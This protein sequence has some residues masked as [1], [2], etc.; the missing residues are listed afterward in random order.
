MKTK[1]NLFFLILITIFTVPT[2]TGLLHPGFFVTDDGNWM[3]IRFSAFYEALR[4]GQFPVRF[5]YRLNNSYGYPVADF[6]Y[7]L[8]MYIGVFIHI[9]KFNFVDTI[10]II[11]GLSMLGSSIFCFLWLKKKYTN[12]SAMIGTIAYTFFP[13]HLYD[14][15]VRGSIGEVLALAILPFIFWQIERNNLVFASLGIALLITAHNSLALLLLPVIFI[16]IVL[17]HS[18]SIKKW[19]YSFILGFGLSAF[20]WVPAIYDRQYTFFDKIAVSNYSNYFITEKDVGLIGLVSVLAVLVSIVLF[21][22]KKNILFVYF[23]VLSIIFTLLTQPFSKI[24]WDIFPFTNLIQFPFRLL[25]IV[26]LAVA[27]L[28]AYQINL[29]KGKKLFFVSLVYVLIIFISS[30][31]YIYPKNF[32]NYPDTFYSTNLDSTTVKNEY[33]PIWLKNIPIS[34]ASKKVK[35]IDGKGEI[36]NLVNNGNLSFTVKTDRKSQILINTIYYPGFIVRVNGSSTPID[37]KQLG[38]IKFQ[39]DKGENMVAVKF[40]E[41]PIRLFADFIS[42]IFLILLLVPPILKINNLHSNKD[43]L[44]TAF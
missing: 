28:I 8:F 26:C 17:L 38:L 16:Y 36:L 11:F 5:L 30:V 41:T 22:R 31:N 6:L 14:V 1:S 13:Y 25:S 18:Q 34:I 27:V 40:T 10:K 15:Y 4:S 39:V 21:F 24:I 37:Y 44:K 33:M 2:I 3:V 7:P 9:L 19:C 20:F 43:K 12:I 42:L 23:F 32:Q 29:L 35:I